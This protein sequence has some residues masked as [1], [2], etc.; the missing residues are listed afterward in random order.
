MAARNWS[1]KQIDDM[2]NYKQKAE[3]ERELGSEVQL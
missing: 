2:V 3:R 1:R